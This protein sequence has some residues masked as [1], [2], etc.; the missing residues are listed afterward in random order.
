MQSYSYKDIARM[1]NVSIATVSHVVNKTRYV[2]PELTARVLSVIEQV[3]YKQNII[4]G[5][6]RNKKT[7]TIGLVLPDSTNEVFAKIGLTVDQHCSRLGYNV[8][9]CNS[10]YKESL[11]RANI[12]SLRMKNIDGVIFIPSSDSVEN[13]KLLQRLRIPFVLVNRS[14]DD[15]QVFQV[16]VDN[17]MIGYEAAK[18]MLSKGRKKLIYLDRVKEIQYS[19][20]RREGFIRALKEYDDPGV[21]YTIIRSTKNFY[22]G[23][24]FAAKYLIEQETKFDAVVTYNDYQA[25]GLMSFLQEHGIRIPHE[26]LVFGCDN[27]QVSKYYSPSLSTMDYPTTEVGVRSADILLHILKNPEETEAYPKQHEF[28]TQLIERESTAITI[29]NRG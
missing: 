17:E 18:H 21:S 6:L 11:E 8:I 23:G 3:N 20:L 25:I 7:K 15:D 2:S 28:S 12:D 26:V 19:K 1:A 9:F 24:F 10:S 4:A 14:I 27:M 22:D 13:I 16:F 29:W 5:S